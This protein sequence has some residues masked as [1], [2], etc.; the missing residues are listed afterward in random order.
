MGREA[1]QQLSARPCPI[2]QPAEDGAADAFEPNPELIRISDAERLLLYGSHY[3]YW[4][5]RDP[6]TAM[7]G[8]DEGV[9]RRVLG[10]NALDFIPRLATR[11]AAP[12]R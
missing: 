5:H 3:P 8:W 10:D 1:A 9:R 2:R 7:S 6:V 12:S 11:A 4:D